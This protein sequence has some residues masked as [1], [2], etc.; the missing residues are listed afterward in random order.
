MRSRI[1]ELR[2]AGQILVDE[3]ELAAGVAGP[4]T[5]A[6]R[7]TL[8]RSF[9]LAP[10]QLGIRR[11]PFGRLVVLDPAHLH[12]AIEA[13]RASVRAAGGTRAV[14]EHGEQD[15]RMELAAAVRLVE[16]ERAVLVSLGGR[17]L[18]HCPAQVTADCEVELP[19]AGQVEWEFDGDGDTVFAS[20]ATRM[21]HAP[22]FSRVLS[23]RRG[24]VWT[25]STGGRCSVELVEEA[26]PRLR[27]RFD[28]TAE[29]G[30]RPHFEQYV[31]ARL[32][33]LVESSTIRRRNIFVCGECET[34]I[35]EEQ[36]R[37]RRERGLDWLPCNVC[38]AR[39]SLRDEWLR[40]DDT[41]G[42]AAELDRGAGVA[43]RRDVANLVLAGKRLTADYD[44]YIAH[45]GADR[46]AAVR[47]AGWVEDRGI[48]AWLDCWEQ[49]PVDEHVLAGLRVALVF[50]G[51]DLA[52]AWEDPQTHAVL[53]Q[54][55][56]RR[57]PVVRVDLP[58]RKR[59]PTFPDWL[60][61]VAVVDF[62][63]VDP[64]PVEELTR[65]I[66]GWHTDTAQ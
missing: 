35:T 53:E 66:T 39:V 56:A 3:A 38:A 52:L 11:L 49:S 4:L 45:A 29:S 23:W 28:K 32:E 44:A 47:I 37:K 30:A 14:D 21:S 40:N 10:M 27:L 1:V 46:D 65:W 36:V 60:N 19:S 20:L 17:L 57:C 12:E 9:G 64:N 50:V 63:V 33:R 22:L 43:R 2:S 41:A 34:K 51:R 24:G 62:A 31:Q 25:A 7:A 16:T 13:L 42:I 6:Q 18:L 15:P 59:D 5:D 61:P 26:G 8:E 58:G 54:L 55:V 48:H